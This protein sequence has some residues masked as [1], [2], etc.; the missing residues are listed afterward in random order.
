M[1]YNLTR[2]ELY[3]LIGKK[4]RASETIRYKH[5]TSNIRFLNGILQ[6]E[7]AIELEFP[8]VQRYNERGNRIYDA[9]INVPDVG[10]LNGDK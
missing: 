1:Y 6:Q 9:W 8:D 4:E 3:A 5:S 2:E 10:K 7:I